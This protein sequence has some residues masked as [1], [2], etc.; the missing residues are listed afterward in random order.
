M[1]LLIP[2][3]FWSLVVW[4]VLGWERRP[5]A[6]RDWIP[7]ILLVTTLVCVGV[8]P[9]LQG[10]Y[11]E[12][13]I[14]FIGGPNPYPVETISRSF[15][16]LG[17]GLGA[18]F[19]ALYALAR[20]AHRLPGPGP[21]ARALKLTLVVLLLRVYLEKLGVS[22]VVANFMGIIWLIVPLPVYFAREAAT[23]RSQ[24]KF[25]AWTFGY[26]FGIRA[27][28]VVLMLLVTHFELGTHF[29]NSGV[30][31]YT[32]FDQDF[33]VEAHS[34]EQYRNLIFL[35]QLFLWTAV[36]VLAGLILGWPTY[37]VASRRQ[38]EIA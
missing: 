14:L 6:V 7:R 17:F 15:T 20:W 16:A 28:V 8:A 1:G 29:D 31:Q 34:W 32:V 25:W 18:L 2:F 4:L 35:P 22:A 30:T 9:F 33:T 36:T 23:V 5:E 27:L 24:R 26:A 37:L 19:M 38:R 11:T 13:V 12:D 10:E 3:G 21:S